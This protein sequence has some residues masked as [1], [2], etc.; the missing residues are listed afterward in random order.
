MRLN[1][2]QDETVNNI[3]SLLHFMSAGRDLVSGDLYSLEDFKK[4]SGQLH[5]ALMCLWSEIACEH[6]VEEIDAYL[7]Y[8]A[9]VDDEF[10]CAE[11]NDKLGDNTAPQPW[12]PA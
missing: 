11:L 4:F 1:E 7:D 10:R 6:R 8:R 3:V 9:S 12:D 5:D 2:T